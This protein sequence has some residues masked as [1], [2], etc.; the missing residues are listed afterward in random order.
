MLLATPYLSSAITKPACETLLHRFGYIAEDYG[1]ALGYW[2]KVLPRASFGQVL[3]IS[4][5]FCRFLSL[6]LSLSAI[7]L[8]FSS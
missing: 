7:H 3:P 8:R 5:P 6:S 4:V 1:E 2:E